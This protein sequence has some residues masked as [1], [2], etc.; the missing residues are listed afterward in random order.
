MN[1]L[2]MLTRK[3]REKNQHGNLV[4][5][6]FIKQIEKLGLMLIAVSDSSVDCSATLASNGHLLANRINVPSQSSGISP[7]NSPL[8][9]LNAWLVAA[10]TI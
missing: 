2:Q 8:K 5:A 9:A 4:K 6:N 3:L 10:F 1:E 7:F